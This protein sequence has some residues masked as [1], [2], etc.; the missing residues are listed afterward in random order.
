MA[1]QREVLKQT[2][3]PWSARTM[4]RA[5]VSHQPATDNEP[6]ELFDLL[7]RDIATLD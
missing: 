3:V 6:E 4:P 2:V 1:S 5:R 7:A